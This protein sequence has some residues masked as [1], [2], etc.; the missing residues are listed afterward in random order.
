MFNNNNNNYPAQDFS[1]PNILGDKLEQDDIMNEEKQ[2]QPSL[3]FDIKNK[4]MSHLT[5][6]QILNAPNPSITEDNNLLYI[7]NK[8]ITQLFLYGTVETIKQQSSHT[9]LTLNDY[10]GKITV[11]FWNSVDNNSSKGIIFCL[12]MWD[13]GSVWCMCGLMFVLFVV[14]MLDMCFV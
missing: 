9:I 4:T 3:I 10:S 11:K 5:V 8:P 2:H 6:K 1:G 12:G 13:N 14:F 7:D